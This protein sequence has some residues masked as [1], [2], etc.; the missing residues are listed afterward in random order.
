MLKL[1][2]MPQYSFEKMLFDEDYLALIRK[3]VKKYRALRPEILIVAGIG[4]SNL[5]ALAIWRALR[6]NQEI[7]FAETLDARRLDRMLRHIE[8]KDRGPAVIMIISK[9]GTTTETIANASVI[10]P[11]LKKAD[12]VIAITDENSVLWKWAR[13]NKFDVLPIPKEVGGRYSV[14]SAVGLFPLALAGINIEKLSAGARKA[15]SKNSAKKTA[16]EIYKHWK[17]GKIIHDWFIFEPDLE[18]VGRW[19]R[20]LVGE[21]L[22]KNGKGITPTVSIGTTDLHSVG[23]LYLGGPKDKFTTFISVKNH[24]KDFAI[25]DGNSL[26]ALVP[27][28]AGKQ[29]G[30]ILDAILRGVKAAYKKQGL[31]FAEAELKEISEELLGE[32]MQT[33][34]METVYL[35]KLMGVNP[36]DQ[37]Q[38]ELYK[39]ETRKLLSNL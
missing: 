22:G 9:S 19:Y 35:A 32:F 24:G 36:F 13:E 38:V 5:G 7:G 6:G 29:F 3:M 31:P 4:G 39:E 23:Q 20:Q 8:R 33:K 21:S 34:M 16:A 14:F 12:K 17:D 30:S 25:P 1:I 15:V 27:D 28:V 11:K 2:T 18:Y 10:L 26:A 37:P